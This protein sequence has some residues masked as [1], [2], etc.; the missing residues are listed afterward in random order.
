MIQKFESGALTDEIKLE[1]MYFYCV[2]LHSG[3]WRNYQAFVLH[4]SFLILTKK[5]FRCQCW[6]FPFASA[7]QLW[8]QIPRFC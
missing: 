1:F 2:T 7:T 6:L 3:E 5:G 4:L 8:L